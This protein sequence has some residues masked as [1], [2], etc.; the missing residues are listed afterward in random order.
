ML[1]VKRSLN[2][3]LK[4]LLR[5]CSTITD[6]LPS[7]VPTPSWMASPARLTPVPTKIVADRV[8]STPCAR[9]VATGASTSAIAAANSRCCLNPFLHVVGIHVP[10]QRQRPL[11]PVHRRSHLVHVHRRRS[12]PRGASRHEGTSRALDANLGGRWNDF[13]AVCPKQVS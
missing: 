8:P 10:C 4:W 9:A 7:M 12:A 2:P 5:A 11:R 1:P 6:G 13:P 3:S